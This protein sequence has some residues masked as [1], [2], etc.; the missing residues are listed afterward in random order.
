MEVLIIW[1]AGI[2]GSGKRVYNAAPDTSPPPPNEAVVARGAWAKRLRQIAPGCSG[3]Q[4][5]ENAIE[6]TAIVYP[7]N[8]TRLVRQHRLDGSTKWCASTVE[9]LG[10]NDVGRPHNCAEHVGTTK[11]VRYRF[12]G[13]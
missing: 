9:A 5:P 12:P 10:T 2:L 6:D 11:V 13:G 3:P 4:D 7:R 1:T 8:A